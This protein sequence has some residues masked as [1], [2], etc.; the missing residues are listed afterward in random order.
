[1][2]KIKFL[3]VIIGLLFFS[4][5]FTA[6]NENNPVT[7]AGGNVNMMPSS[8][9]LRGLSID[10]TQM[11]VDFMT[12]TSSNPKQLA[13]IAGQ[14]G[15]ILNQ[16][17]PTEITIQ[18]IREGTYKTLTL[19]VQPPMQDERMADPIFGNPQRG[20]SIVVSG[21]YNNDQ[22]TFRTSIDITREVNL[23]QGILANPQGFASVTL[24]VNTNSWFVKNGVVLDPMDEANRPKIE[25]NI[26]NSFNE[27]IPN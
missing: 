9:T 21:I 17:S 7:P 23:T 18:K 2:K 5:F 27:A 1:M 19:R 16:N 11:L 8:G 26:R 6:C 3:S 22:F 25:E 12:E 13:V 15:V 24:N 10:K 14:F 20:S 4:Y